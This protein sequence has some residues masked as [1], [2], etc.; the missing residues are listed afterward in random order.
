[1][2]AACRLRQRRN[3]PDPP[4]RAWRRRASD[5]RTM[6][7]DDRDDD[8]A[9]DRP[10]PRLL[11]SAP[12]TPA[13]APKAEATTIMVPSRSVPLA[14]GGGRGDDE[15]AHQHHADGC[16]PMTMPMTSR[17]VSSMSSDGHRVARLAPKSRSKLSSLNSFPEQGPAA[18]APRRRR[19]P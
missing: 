8:R 19:R 18:A 3:R 7:L 15:R 4:A 2:C 11:M 10:V 14:G 9:V 6:T 16:K 1:M 17:M 13:K 12:A 5:S